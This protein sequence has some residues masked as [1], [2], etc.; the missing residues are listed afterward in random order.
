MREWRNRWQLH[1]R[2]KDVGEDWT[3]L[4]EMRSVSDRSRMLAV[5]VVSTLVEN[6]A[7]MAR[8]LESQEKSDTVFGFELAPEAWK[9]RK[10]SS[11]FVEGLE[12]LLD[13]SA[14]HVRVPSAVTLYSMDRHSE[15]VRAGGWGYGLGLGACA[16]AQCRQHG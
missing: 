5:A 1:V 15:K 7:S 2:L 6:E 14:V 4:Q 10:V 12:C 13:D 9:R 3:L 11:D 8:S 16:S